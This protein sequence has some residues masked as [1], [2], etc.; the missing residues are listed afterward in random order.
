VRELIKPQEIVI[1]KKTFSDRFGRFIIE[2]LERGYGTTLGNSLR[3]ILLSSIPGAAVTSVKIEGAF[4]EFSAIPG[5]KE[6]VLQ[7]IQNLKQIRVKLFTDKEK[8]VFLD[9]QG[10][11]KVKASHI[12]IDSE[13]E[14]VD[15]DLLIATL[16]NKKTHLLIEIALA[17]GRGYVQ[18]EDNKRPDQPLGTIPLDSIFSPVEKVKY[19]VKPARIGRKTSFD[20]LLL[21]VSTDGTIK[22]DEAVRE[23]ARILNEYLEFFIREKKEKEM[24]DEEK[25]NFLEQ[26]VE[27]IGISGLSLNALKAAGIEKIGDLVLKNA[28]ELLKMQNFG[29]KSLEKIEKKLVKYNLSLA[30]EESN[31]AQKKRKKAGTA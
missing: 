24:T 31:E 16:E 21:E 2:P 10:P 13:V 19:E 11:S 23:A 5:V 4:H 27:K 18:A 28:K 7:V 6:D 26:K 12:K 30:K 15:P 20:S 1:E 25:K 22:P 3:R 8:K 29:K 14:I 17:K 9:V